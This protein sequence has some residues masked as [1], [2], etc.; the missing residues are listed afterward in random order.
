MAVIDTSSLDKEQ[1]SVFSIPLQIFLGF[2]KK[3]DSKG[4]HFGQR[5]LFGDIAAFVVRKVS[6]REHSQYGIIGSGIY[7]AIEMEGER[8]EITYVKSSANT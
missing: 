1:K 6:S 2:R 4:S 8:E 5:R 7:L 3:F